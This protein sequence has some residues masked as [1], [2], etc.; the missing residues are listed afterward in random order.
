MNVERHEDPAQIRTKGVV[1]L[2]IMFVIDVNKV[3]LFH[4][5]TWWGIEVN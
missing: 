2:E 3:R 1:S 4:D 5:G